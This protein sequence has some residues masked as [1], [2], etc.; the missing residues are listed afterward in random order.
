MEIDL[1]FLG[2]II[3]ENRLKPETHDV[4]VHLKESNI[5]TIMCTGD[6][7]LTALSVAYECEIIGSQNHVVRIEAK[8]GHDIEYF[9]EESLKKTVLKKSK[10][11]LYIKTI[12][13]ISLKFNSYINKNKLIIKSKD[14]NPKIS[15]FNKN[16]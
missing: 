6:N 7:I 3:M 13:L 5:R 15:K 16:Q 8:T 14:I 10:I 9:Y 11:N 1:D 2:L 4:I 12:F